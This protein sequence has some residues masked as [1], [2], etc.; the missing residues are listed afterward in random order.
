MKYA[1]RYHSNNG[2]TKAIAE[3]IASQLGVEAHS[4]DVPLPKHTEVL[5]IGGAIYALK[6]DKTLLNYF[7]NLDPS[8][9][10]KLIIFSTSGGSIFE[11]AAR[12]PRVAQ[13]HG[14]TVEDS[15]HILF[16]AS[17]HKKLGLKGGKLNE[18]QIAEA[19]T[20]AEKIAAAYG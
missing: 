16:G 1:V 2:N 12:M 10:N 6:L 19:K 5:L 3:V 18:K 14:F 11:T 8:L 7:E 20:F 15:C 17:G 13:E 4:L 9:F